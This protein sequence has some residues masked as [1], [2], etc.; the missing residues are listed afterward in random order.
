M[1]PFHKRRLAFVLMGG[2]WHF[3]RDVAVQFRPLFVVSGGTVDNAAAVW[4]CTTVEPVVSQQSFVY[5]TG[6]IKGLPPAE[7]SITSHF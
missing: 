4:R 7:F 1:Y 5:S 6:Y 2:L 3:S